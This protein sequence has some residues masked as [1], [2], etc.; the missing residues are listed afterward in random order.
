MN[1]NSKIRGMIVA[2][3]TALS[4]LAVSYL[5]ALEV[6]LLTGRVSDHAGMISPSVK[7][8]IEKKLAELER[9]DSTQIAVL[10]VPDLQDYSIEEFAIKVAEKWKIGQKKLDNGVIFLVSKQERKMRIEV[11]YGL[12]GRLTD[13]LAGRI[14]DNEVRPFFKAGDFDGG[15]LRGIDGIILA[16]RGEYRGTEGR[17]GET[18]HGGS[19]GSESA[20]VIMFLVF[21]V[22]NMGMGARGLLHGTIAGG[23]MYPIFFAFMSPLTLG[24]LPVFIIIG[25]VIGLILSLMGRGLSSGNTGSGGSSG[26]SGPGG[27]FG[28]G[29][30]GGGG[31]GGG[32]FS[33]GGGSFGGGGAS[34]GW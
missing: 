30:L 26:W 9:T 24:T 3:A 27:G 34:S 17:S 21:L 18:A 6:P 4:L 19:S 11:G 1:N 12:E 10:T 32:G 20:P 28:G 7:A 16:V 25:L 33:G 8:D 31:F 14:L 2:A 22:I 23:I 5:S 29:S 13:L 15:F